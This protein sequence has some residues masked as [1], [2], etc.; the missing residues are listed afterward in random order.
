MKILQRKYD[1]KFF[2]ADSFWGLKLI[3]FSD[4]ENVTTLG[5]YLIT[6]Q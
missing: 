3:D 1:D 6:N 4:P 2:I 5:Y